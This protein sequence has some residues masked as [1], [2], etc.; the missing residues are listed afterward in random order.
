[1]QAANISGQKSGELRI[2]AGSSMLSNMISAMGSSVLGLYVKYQQAKAISFRYQNV[3]ED[4]IE[5]ASLDQF[6]TD[7]DIINLFSTHIADVIESNEV[8]AMTFTIRTK[9]STVYLKASRSIEL[10]P[11]VA[12]I[13][14]VVGSNVKVSSAGQNSST[15]IF[16]DAIPLVF[17]FHAVQL[18]YDKRYY[19]Q[20]KPS[21]SEV[22]IRG[23]AKKEVAKPVPYGTFARPDGFFN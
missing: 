10:G 17:G 18:F 13:Q 19:T 6:L 14:N 9:K 1:L 7:A 16:E 21:K 8:C 2:G 11:D 15:L 4:T 23:K 12:A 22:A 20:L 5:I 3:L